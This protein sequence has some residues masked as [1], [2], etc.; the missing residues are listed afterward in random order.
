MSKEALA[1]LSLFT[2][3]AAALFGKPLA[4]EAHLVTTGMG[5]VYDGI[6][7]LLLTPEDLIPV[8]TMAMYCGLQGA[9]SSRMLL[10]VLP[11]SWFI[12]GIIGIEGAYAPQFPLQVC[13]FLLIGVLVA[14]D[15]HLPA[16]TITIMAAFVGAGHGFL[17]GIAL[18][19]GPAALGLLGIMATLFVTVALVAALV[20][21][22]RFQWLRIV[23]RVLG[24]WTVASGILMLGWYFKGVS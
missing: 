14:A 11:A 5:P 3:F 13:S 24:S 17:N 18:R 12:G 21:S 15:I 22:I 1:R 7:H 19:E 2:L 4:A 10:F 23:V 9:R 8:F 20:I 16:S 6:G